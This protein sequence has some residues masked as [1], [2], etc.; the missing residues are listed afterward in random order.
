MIV[1]TK[2]VAAVLT[3][4]A[5]AAGAHADMMPALCVGTTVQSSSQIGDQT[6][7]QSTHF[8]ALLIDPGMVDLNVPSAACLPIASA[9]GAQK[10]EIRL[11]AQTLEDRHGSFDLCLYALVSL[12][13]FRSGHYVKK[14]CLL[15]V[16]EWYHNGGPDQIGHS[17]VV[18][19]DLLRS[20][21]V[22]CFVQP[23]YFTDDSPPICHPATIVSR[24]RKS[25]FTPAAVASRPPPLGIR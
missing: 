17:Y 16:P 25:Q 3:V 8:P 20:A 6:Y 24:W 15:F 10:S 7:P 23:G 13:L 21:A 22:I 1:G 4:S 5:V 11:S 14:S 2:I 12:A 18:G 9:D 19:P